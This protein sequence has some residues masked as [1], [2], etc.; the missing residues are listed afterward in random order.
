[1]QQCN[2]VC[3]HMLYI[4]VDSTALLAYNCHNTSAHILHIGLLHRKQHHVLA[5]VWCNDV[6]LC[7]L[8]IWFA[9]T[10]KQANDK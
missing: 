3:T 2:W 6:V 4:Y 5:A 7:A 10:T 8:Y 1:M 9:Q